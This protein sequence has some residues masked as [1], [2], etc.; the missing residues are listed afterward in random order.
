MRLSSVEALKAELLDAEGPSMSFLARLA[1]LGEA[2]VA[3]E[4]TYGAMGRPVPRLGVGLGVSPG[5]GFGDYHL[6]IRVCGVS[7]D[8]SQSALDLEAAEWVRSMLTKAPGEIEVGR[9]SCVTGPR[10]IPADDKSVDPAYLRDRHRPMEP[11]Q[12]VGHVDIT[13]GTIGAFVRDFDG[14]YILS[15]AHVLANVNRGVAGDPVSQPGPHDEAPSPESLVAVLD[16]SVR[17]SFV[18]TNFVDCAVA[19]IDPGDEFLVRYS[20][21][22]GDPDGDGRLNQVRGVSELSPPRHLGQIVTKVGRTTGVTRGRV[23]A[24]ML[25]G[26]RVGLG[27]GVATFNDQMEIRGLTTPFSAGGDSGSI[28]FDSEGWGIGLLFAGGAADG[29][30]DVT[31]A[32]RLTRVMRALGV[33][34]E[35]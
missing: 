18:Q 12:S 5:K 29:G 16:R 31:Y 17:I 2:T 7:S 13:A 14:V 10:P 20:A 19:R 11:G 21:A 23:T 8:L 28:I 26:I 32:N 1:H 9:I 4:K 25:D 27:T 6:C 22:I 30:V 24:M 33:D 34:L 3:I 15:N 35:A